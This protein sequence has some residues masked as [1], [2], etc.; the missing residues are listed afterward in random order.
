MS[1]LTARTSLEPSN[2]VFHWIEI[3]VK[4]LYNVCFKTNQKEWRRK[5]GRHHSTTR[6]LQATRTVPSLFDMKASA[7]QSSKHKS[8][9]RIVLRVG[10][11][12]EIVH[13]EVIAVRQLFNALRGYDLPSVSSV[14]H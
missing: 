3:Y 14:T 10:P 8:W 1:I 4:L 6:R 11:T 7:H 12:V 2:G 5:T 13:P 9:F